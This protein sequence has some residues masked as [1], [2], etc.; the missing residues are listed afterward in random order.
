M[1]LTLQFSFA[2]VVHRVFDSAPPEHQ[3]VFLSNGKKLKAYQKPGGVYVFV[4]EKAGEIEIICKGYQNE[5]VFAQ[6]GAEIHARL[7]PD[8]A[9]VPPSGW[10]CYQMQA[11]PGELV[12]CADTSYHVRLIEKPKKREAV[13]FWSKPGIVG[14]CLSWKTP[15]GEEIAMIVQKTPPDFYYL[16]KPLTDGGDFKKGYL[17]RAMSNHAAFLVAPDGWEPDSVGKEKSGWD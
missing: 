4:D 1:A 10:T 17:A 7:Y 11:Q 12:F 8:G 15:Q 6:E 5:R 13:R 2:I 3:P 16:D 9:Y 14:G